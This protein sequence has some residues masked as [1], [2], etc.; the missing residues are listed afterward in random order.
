[1]ASYLSLCCYV[2]SHLCDKPNWLFE[3]RGPVHFKNVDKPVVCYW[4]IENVDRLRQPKPS[5]QRPT[6]VPVFAEFIPPAVG[7]SRRH[8]SLSWDILSPD[9]TR[10]IHIN[11]PKG[12]SSEDVSE[13]LPFTES[14]ASRLAQMGCPAYNS[15][16]PSAVPSRSN[17]RT[18]EDDGIY[19][20]TSFSEIPQRPRMG[21]D[22]SHLH[23]IRTEK[24][25]R[26]SVDYPSRRSQS[27]RL[28]RHHTID[29]VNES[30]IDL[31]KSLPAGRLSLSHFRKSSDLTVASD[32]FVQR[33]AE[34]SYSELV[35]KSSSST[36]GSFDTTHSKS[37]SDVKTS[38]LSPEP[39]RKVSNIS[40]HSGID[41][42]C[43][44]LDPTEEESEGTSENFQST[45]KTGLVTCTKSNRRN[46]VQQ[47]I[48]HFEKLS[49]YE[50]HDTR[51]TR[52]HG[53]VSHTK[54]LT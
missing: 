31:S 39:V 1:M 40:E 7:T 53:N 3:V 44:P 34:S 32:L 15:Q 27:P 23:H 28:G 47:K 43:D 37:S 9:V 18:S 25:Q 4:L 12:I 42:G 6:E 36:L 54:S 11:E 29:E 48:Q 17:T 8:S 41:S 30:S 5:L 21:S 51:R 26:H 35:Q 33:S 49:G 13:S 19:F 46:S 2:H 50:P 24:F 16:P 20:S 22:L 38:S 52:S 10:P 14:V 45:R